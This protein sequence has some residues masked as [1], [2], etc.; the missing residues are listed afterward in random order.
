MAYIGTISIGTPPQE[1]KVIFD[2]GSTDLWVPSIYCY[3]SACG[4]CPPPH[5]R[6]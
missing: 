5:L 2:T 4:E 1:F 3:T 6:P